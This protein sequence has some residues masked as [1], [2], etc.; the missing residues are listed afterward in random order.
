MEILRK[1]F[2]NAR[3]QKHCNRNEKCFDGHISSL[4]MAEERL[5]ELENKSVETCKFEKQ[6]E[7][8]SR[9]W[10]IISK[11]YGTTITDVIYASWEYQREKK[12]KQNIQNI[13]TENFPL[14]HPFIIC[15]EG[16][17]IMIKGQFSRKT[18]IFNVYASN[19]RASKYTK[20]SKN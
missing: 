5:S 1:N 20:Q 15:K 18:T 14:N 13:M 10:I 8:K 9:K 19:N 3:D 2:L 12:R 6:R 4:D 11:N 17:Y 16:N 7:K